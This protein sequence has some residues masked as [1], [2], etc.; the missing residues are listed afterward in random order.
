M[1]VRVSTRDTD[2]PGTAAPLGSVTTPVSEPLLIWQK[3]GNSVRTAKV[4]NLDVQRIIGNLLP[5]RSPPPRRQRVNNPIRLVAGSYYNMA[6]VSNGIG[7]RDPKRD[8]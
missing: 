8:C 5:T 1:P 4:I 2:A 7:G 6:F 3:A